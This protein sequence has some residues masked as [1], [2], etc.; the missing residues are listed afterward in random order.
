MQ[1]RHGFTLIELLVVIAII[2]ILAAILFPV[3]AQAREKA[4][5]TSCLSNLK[6]IGLSTMMYVQDYDETFPPREDW[7]ADPNP[8]IGPWWIL[9]NPYIK[10]GVDPNNPYDQSKNGNFWRCPTDKN[11]SAMSYTCNPFVFGLTHVRWGQNNVVPSRSL[12]GID[13]SATIAIA[14]DGN[15][16]GNGGVIEDLVNGGDIQTGGC[17]SQSQESVDC[18]KW[19]SENWILNDYT[20]VNANDGKV[21][22]PGN[23]GSYLWKSFSYR[24]SRAGVKTGVANLVFADGHAKG[25]HAVSLKL[26]NIF[27][28]TGTV[29][30]FCNAN[31]GAAGCP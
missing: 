16:D 11:A 5:Q 15:K 19:Y 27:P 4:R 21:G 10:V 24:H 12:A 14:G 22:V 9:V 8:P 26:E 17:Q 7:G 30:G 29:D 13:K 28:S 6:Q 1:R 25:A 20:E 23:G 2:A 18:A 3:F 31:V